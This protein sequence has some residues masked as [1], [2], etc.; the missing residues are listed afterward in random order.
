MG[1]NTRCQ[2]TEYTDYTEKNED[3][4]A[5]IGKGFL[6]SEINSHPGPVN[7]YE[8]FFKIS[9]LSEY[10]V[11]NLQFFIRPRNTQNTRKIKLKRKRNWRMNTVLRSITI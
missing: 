1:R 9:V 5:N 2:T 7:R 3:G 8:L 4:T 11:V 6:E 10:S